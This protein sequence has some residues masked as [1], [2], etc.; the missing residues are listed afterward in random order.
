MTKSYVLSDE[1]VRLLILAAGDSQVLN[2][3]RFSQEQSEALERGVAVLST[4]LGETPIEIGDRE[5]RR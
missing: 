1:Q 5:C 3:K 4:T 2:S